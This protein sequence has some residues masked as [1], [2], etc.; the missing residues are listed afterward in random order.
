[1]GDYRRV[2]ETQDK[3]APDTP[4]AGHGSTPDPA[5]Q[6]GARYAN[7][8][9]PVLGLYGGNDQRVNST[10]ARADSA[11][12]ANGKTFEHRIFE[13]AGHGFLRQQDGAEGANLKAAQEA[14]PLTITWFRRHLR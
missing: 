9:A 1:M 6:I 4:A 13:G 7:V 5:T 12:K 11:M 10:I 14:W 3:S 8:T 2:N